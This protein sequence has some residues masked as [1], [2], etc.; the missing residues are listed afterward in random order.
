MPRP[1]PAQP[2]PRMPALPAPDHRAAAATGT[3][4][5]RESPPH[6]QSRRQPPRL[7]RRRNDP[8]LLGTR[9]SPPSL[10][11]RDHLDLGLRHRTIHRISPMTSPVLSNPQGGLHRRV[12]NGE[13]FLV[14]VR[15]VLAPSLSQGDIVVIDNLPA[16]KVE[17]S[18]PRL[19]P[20]AQSC[21]I[22]RPI[23]RTS[24]P[25]RWHS[26]NSKRCCARQP[27]EQG[28]HSGTPSP[29]SSAPLTLPR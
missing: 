4:G 21:S 22:C 10:H 16:H 15:N 14:Y 24:I 23:R 9:P 7:K 1:P 6:A 18:A 19:K 28:I 13:A 20:A 2:S 27:L 17:G 25:S 3:T 26:P 11:R 12:T 29:K 8:F 5:S